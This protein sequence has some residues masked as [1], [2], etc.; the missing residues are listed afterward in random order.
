[1]KYYRPVLAPTSRSARTKT[2]V[3]ILVDAREASPLPTVLKAA[4]QPSI[5]VH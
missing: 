5:N 3:D 1:M 2:D 4:D